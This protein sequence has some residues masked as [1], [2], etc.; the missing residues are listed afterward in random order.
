MAD[1]SVFASPDFDAH[2]YA[3]AILAGEPYPSQHGKAAKSSKG[4]GLEPAKEDIS[5]AISKLNH[6]IDDVSKQLKNVVTT[7]HEELL[8]QAAGVGDLEGSLTTVRSGLGELESH[9]DR[10][11]LKIRVPYQSLQNHVNRLERLQQALDVLRRMSRFVILARRLEAQMA[12]MNMSETERPAVELKS[13]NQGAPRPNPGQTQDNEEEKERTIAKA[14]LSVAELTALLDASPDADI[15]TSLETGE[16]TLSTDGDSPMTN[17]VIPLRSINAVSAHVP[18]IE[19][20]RTKITTEMESMVLIG[21]STLNQSLLA[22]SLQ[23]A[24]N[25]RVLPDVVQSLVLDLA[26]AVDSRIR[27]AF[28]LSQISKEALAKEPPP[29][30]HSLMYKSRIRTEPTNVTVPQ[31]TAVL[32]AR[33]ETLVEELTGCCVKVYTLE[34]VLKIKKDP[35]TQTVFLDEAMQLL[36]NQPSSTFWAALGGALEKQ[37][38][39]AA[40]GSSFLQQT[41]STGYPRFLRLFHE[42]FA[43]IAVHTD[44][45]YTQTQQSPETILVL[46]A[47]SNFEALY[48]SRVSSRLNEVVAQAFAGG[49]RAPP[50]MNEGVNIARTIANELDSSKFDPLLVKAVAR[51]AVSSLEMLLSRMDGLIVRD[52]SATTLIGPT[53]TQQQAL[54][55]SLATCLYHCWSRLQKL[56]D[57][58]P[59]PVYGIL[60]LAIESIH[61][62]YDRIVD[63]LLNAI[64][65]ELA[66]VIA[67]LHRNDFSAAPDPMSGMGG[68]ASMYM[69]ELTEK[70][71]FIKLEI[72]SKFNVGQGGRERIISIVKYV[73]RTFVL[74]ISIAKPLG[75]SGKLQIISDM[76]ELEFG[77]SAFMTDSQTRRR[78]ADWGSV[79]DEYRSLRAMR[80]LLFLDNNSLSSRERTTGLPPLI[81]LHHILVRSPIPLPHTLHGWQEAEYVRWVDEH[82]Q[83]EAWTLVDG[84][85]SRWEKVSETEGRNSADAFEYIQL[86][87]SVLTLAR[88][89][90]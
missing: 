54:N 11:R 24:Y 73:L 25:L 32:W 68:S 14:A 15:G 61:G 46:R 80:Q 22:S 63:P 52:R 42:F 12:E 16:D 31:W 3:N 40:K 28:D 69:K 65:R 48:L 20:A 58:Y 59:Q 67:K 5:V 86:A 10:L 37:S 6:G 8:V 56:E 82:S 4:P 53:S 9:L 83:E 89:S 47:L 76:T 23:T 62:T 87:K 78:G 2:E 45:V 34:K 43:K 50:G 66:S 39:D 77:L 90:T 30:S 81:V 49:G 21:L 64:K 70:L 75:E 7:H 55:G 29:P 33:L 74:H 13:A 44:T 1:Y 51:N 72:L 57:E 85:L 17:A 27:A 18:F 35:L 36:E 60:R 88:E 26:D 71:S 84:G 19:A 38:R 41:L 79:G